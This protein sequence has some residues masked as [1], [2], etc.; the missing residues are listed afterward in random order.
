VEVDFQPGFNVLTGE[1]GAGKSILIG[2]LNLVLGARS[3]GDV[4]RQGTDKAQIDAIFLLPRLSRRLKDLLKAHDL[5]LDGPELHLSRVITK[6]SRSKGYVNGAMV[7]IS[8]LSDIGD[9]LVDVHGQHD[10]QSLLKS[11]RQLELLDAY[12]GTE[13]DVSSLRGQVESYRALMER[14]EV[15]ANDDRDRTRQMEFLRFEVTEIDEAHLEPGEGEALKARINLITNSETIFQAAQRAYTTLYEQEDGAVVDLLGLAN[16]ELDELAEIDERFTPLAAQL[17]EAQAAIEAIAS[18]L[19]GYT[20]ELEFDPEE[21]NELNRRNA[22]IGALKRK[23]GGSVEEILAYRDKAAAELDSYENRDEQLA[24]LKK[25]AAALRTAIESAGKLLTAARQKAARKIEKEVT[26]ALQD[27]GMKGAQ[28]EAFLQPVDMSLSGFDRA[29]F[30]LAANKGESMKPLKQVAS[31]GEISRIML[32]I[33]TVLAKA[34]TIPSLIFDEVDAGIGGDVA[35]KV[36]Q[37]LRAI[38]SSHQVLSITHLAQIA[39]VGDAHFTVAK[40]ST[41]G[42]TKS[43]VSPISGEAREKEIAR[44]L[45]GS[46]SKVSLDHAREL[47]SGTG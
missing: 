13:D 2:A 23:Y 26:A 19:R 25:E 30:Q 15:L 39:A 32:A 43:Q 42:R 33:K 20:E 34:D 46:I 40:A 17:T 21:L 27:L 24:A 7:P 41:N 14:I 1:T 16:R 5:T 22:L 35:R 29:N 37:K 3:T 18:E 47:L 8:V 11:D 31:G 9:E 38:A 28:F 4:L 44:L 36:A 6:D 45:D 10:H 12:A